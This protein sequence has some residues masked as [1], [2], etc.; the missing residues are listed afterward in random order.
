MTGQDVVISTS[1]LVMTYDD[2][3]MGQNFRSP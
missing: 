1:D 2:G 3:A